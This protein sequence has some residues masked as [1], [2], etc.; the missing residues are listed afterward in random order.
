M[1]SERLAIS[2]A[3]ELFGSEALVINDNQAACNYQHAEWYPRETTGMRVADKL[4]RNAHNCGVR[5]TV[6]ECLSDST[7]NA[8]GSLLANGDWKPL[9]EGLDLDGVFYWEYD[10]HGHLLVMLK[11]RYNTWASMLPRRRG[12][13]MWRAKAWSRAKFPYLSDLRFVEGDER[14]TY[15]SKLRE[16]FGDIYA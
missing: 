4:S 10:S 15:A 9:Y 12:N 14:V 1:W 3:R 13:P 16:V 5:F 11:T 7:A 8:I 2:I 6:G